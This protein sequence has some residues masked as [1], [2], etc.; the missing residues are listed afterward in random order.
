M[1]KNVI[2]LFDSASEA[3]AT[4]QEL[5]DAG[6]ASDRIS[7]LGSNARNEYSTDDPGDGAA[8]GATGGAVMGG[9]GGLLVG[10]GAL[11][12]PGIG[13]VISAGTLA[14]TLGATAVG[15]GIGAATGGVIGALVDAGIPDE[16]A[17]V[18]AESIRRGGSL[19][20][21]STDSDSEVD[22]VVQIM[23]RHNVVD[24]DR[25]G[26]EYRQS[27]WSRFDTDAQPYDFSGRTTASTYNATDRAS[28]GTTDAAYANTGSTTLEQ[29]G[30][31]KIPVV[32]EEL[33]VGKRA[34]EG[35][36]VR[37]YTR[38]QEQPVN[39]QVTLHKEH[40]EVHRQPVD[41]TLGSADLENFQEGTFEVR[42]RSEEAVVDKQARVVEEV[43]IKKNVEEQTET[44]QD[45]VRR[46]GVEVENL[47]GRSREV[48][49]TEYGA[50]NVAGS[51]DEG[52][53]ERNASKL[54]NAVERGL[55]AD[56]DND[57]D[58]GRR[59]LRNN[60]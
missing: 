22:Q 45:T 28:Y 24:I 59:D 37:V 42:E 38:V 15:A 46:T 4:L 32:E 14:T 39:E 20:S 47:T 41:R 55:D 33:Q 53:I 29:G 27:G 35:G 56:L 54:G 9:L 23:R 30:E 1:A 50:G 34:V 12:I 57:G 21:V 25:R 52:A 49:S 48:G 36:G 11:A 17:H 60:I 6:Y 40:V 31:M 58:I 18:Y 2:G 5:R 19:I 43:H 3:Q 51:P 16:D 10:L 8:V 13:P 44:I 7:L 26:G